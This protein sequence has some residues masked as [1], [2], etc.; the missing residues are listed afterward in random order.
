MIGGFLVIASGCSSSAPEA[1]DTLD[2]AARRAVDEGRAVSVLVFLR[3][4]ANLDAAREMPTKEARGRA[5]FALLSTHAAQSQADLMRALAA[6]PGVRT[7]AFYIANAVLVE[8][9]PPDL[10]ARLAARKDVARVVVDREVPF[11]EATP[12]PEELAAAAAAEGGLSTTNATR[13][14]SE[15]GVKGDGVVVGAQ[16]TGYDWTHPALKKQYRGWNGVTADHRYSWH[17]AIHSGTPTACGFDSPVPCDDKTHGTHTLGT[18]VGDDGGAN[19]IGMAPGAKW[20]GCRNMNL[21]VGRPSTYLECFEFFLAP[22]PQGTNPRTEGRPEL[23]PDVINN[24]WG[25]GQDETCRGRE[26]VA[27]LANLEAAGITVVVAAGNSGSACGSID[28]QPA[29]VSDST[30]SVGTSLFGDGVSFSS[31]GPSALDGKIG[32]DV[33]APGVD[34]R[35][36][37]PGGGY[38]KK[39]G[40]SMSS[41]HVAGEVALVLSA[42][43]SLRGK[44]RQITEIV[45]RTAKPMRSSQSCGGVSGSAIPNNTLGFGMIDAY[46]AVRRAQTAS[47]AR[48]ER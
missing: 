14:W 26:F 25:C 29:T 31:R 13:V 24:S 20:I 7:R 5:A 4:M 27:V 40:T 22:Y 12:L 47:T 41:P 15:L 28:A 6:E 8:D 21:G 11:R 34:V 3:D 9:A 32:P 44:P 2:A 43:P 48:T 19:A 36:S 33:V 45:T 39:S 18:I 17:D 23:A 35:S 42:V 10:V 38:E 46:A 30:L 1:T 37:V 16:D